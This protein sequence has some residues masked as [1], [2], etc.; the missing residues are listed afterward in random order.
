MNKGKIV[1]WLALMAGGAAIGAGALAQQQVPSLFAQAGY[2]AREDMLDA[3]KLIPPAPK[4]GTLSGLRD[5]EAAGAAVALRG[6]ARWEQARIDANLDPATATS[7]FSC[8][9]G[10]PIG[11]QTT[12][13]LNALL[14]RAAVDLGMST[15]AVKELY[16]RPRP[17]TVNREA[18][19][20]PEA[21]AGLRN[22]GAYPSGHAAIGYGW[23]LLLA[24]V[25]PARAN[26][27][28]AR[29]WA[30]ADSRRVCNVHWLSD[31]EQ[32]SRMGAAVVARLHASADFQ[33][34]LKKVRDE[35]K[36]KAARLPAPDCARENAAFGAA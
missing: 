34:D 2:I 3:V 21:E 17:F 5:E 10:I 14:L 27:L 33:K 31:V 18:I 6:S 30:F 24:E 7:A 13:A 35:L 36:K 8:A 28:V 4:P 16:K 1:A 32:G 22:N 11:P 12:P 20:T 29:G 25:L 26:Q 19:C 9:A 23:G 15:G